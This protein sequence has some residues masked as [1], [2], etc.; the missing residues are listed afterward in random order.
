M[1]RREIRNNIQDKWT[2]YFLYIMF[3]S[4]YFITLMCHGILQTDLIKSDIFLLMVRCN[5]SVIEFL[6]YNENT[7]D[8]MQIVKYHTISI[9]IYIV[10]LTNILHNMINF[11]FIISRFIRFF[12]MAQSIKLKGNRIPSKFHRK[13]S[14]QFLPRVVCA[15]LFYRQNFPNIYAVLGNST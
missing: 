3:G 14:I 12:F 11:P 9:T 10:R 4:W 1:T 13:G 8:Y 7:H 5:I 2:H 15:T 6:I